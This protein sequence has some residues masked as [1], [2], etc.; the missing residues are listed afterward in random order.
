MDVALFAGF[1]ASGPVHVP[2]P[3]EDA[4]QFTAIFGAD[5]A[6]AREPGGSGTRY[7]YLAPAVRAFFRN[8]GKRCWIVRLA[9]QAAT[10]NRFRVP[11]LKTVSG[12]DAFA[13]A[14]SAGSW[15][16]GLRV[17]TNLVRRGIR[18]H[19]SPLPGDDPVRLEA[20]ISAPN[21]IVPGDLLRLTD[22][23]STLFL[24]AG[25][26]K[27]IAPNIVEVVAEQSVEQ[28]ESL[29]SSP[30]D[31]FVCER[32]LFDLNVDGVRIRNL[33]FAP[34]HPRYWGAL[35]DDESLYRQIAASLDA[36]TF[37][38]DSPWP[39][40]WNAALNPRFPLAAED[41]ASF[42]IPNDMPPLPGEGNSAEP[43]STAALE[44][45]GLV[46]F[47]RTLFLDRQ[48]ADTGVRDIINEAD[49]IRYEADPTRE[50]TGI[51]AAL[52]VEEA[53]IFAVPD[54]VHRG[55][56]SSGDTLIVST[57]TFTPPD[58]NAGKFLDCSLIDPVDAVAL[59]CTTFG[60]DQFR[61]IWDE[62]AGAIDEIE[63]SLRDDFTDAVVIDS[64][65]NRGILD[66][67]RDTPGTYHYRLRRHIGLRVSPYSNAIAVRISAG[68]GYTAI[69]AEGV[70]P[71]LL[72]VQTAMLRMCA[73]RGDLLTLLTL[74]LGTREQEAIE[75]VMQLG[76][77]VESQTL[78]Y[79]AVV[80]P[81]LT[82][83]EESDVENLRTTPPDGATA[84]VMAARAISRGAWV[85][86]ANEPLLGVVALEPPMRPELLQSLQ[87]AQVNIVRHAPAGFLCLDSDTLSADDDLRPINVRR[88]LI[89][90]RRAALAVGTNYVFEPNDGVLRRA[91]K[92]ALQSMLEF[93]FTRGAFSGKISRAAFQVN[94]DAGVNSQNDNDN[95]RFIAEVRVAPSRPLSFLTVRLR[96]SG[97]RTVA[98]EVR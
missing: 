92:R 18:L 43:Q 3:V 22:G 62:A 94:T 58:A 16:D 67:H 46:P 86:P 71:L 4:A 63:E 74:P 54:A 17:S 73:G 69:D 51:H 45:E 11:S 38:P 59:F 55:W 68:A 80:H 79:G 65:T 41:H 30:L 47:D 5:L 42:F 89:L 1:A 60:D 9:G 53:T 76:S 35:P 21:E 52:A 77:V 8:G 93:M 37:R 6:L 28:P 57:S 24:F 82:G 48:L 15:S 66:V 90:V 29:P 26:V 49:F 14:R 81:W 97:D 87:D 12:H 88:V 40:V 27:L 50:L 91:I 39:D 7:A 84:G 31:H 13:V 34:R 2:V 75:H 96:Q 72:D 64:S 78:S 98:E 95:G 32:L 25:T 85:A 20:S 70:S 36:S 33:A 44:R 23:P 10:A 61:L 19:G 83:R 56:D